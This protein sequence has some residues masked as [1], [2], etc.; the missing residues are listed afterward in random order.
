[1]SN[2]LGE[3]G[4]AGIHPP[5]FRHRVGRLSRPIPAVFSS[6][7]FSTGHDLTD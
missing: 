4:S 5:L 7:R 6:N 3:N 1:M 2:Q